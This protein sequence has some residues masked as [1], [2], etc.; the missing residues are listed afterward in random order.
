MASSAQDAPAH[1]RAS[2]ASS[3]SSPKMDAATGSPLTV[4]KRLFSHLS[5]TDRDASCG[6]NGPLASQLQPMPSGCSR[7]RSPHTEVTMRDDLDELELLVL[8]PNDRSE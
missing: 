3:A 4:L 2:T 8:G 5:L 7:T 6:C 1:R